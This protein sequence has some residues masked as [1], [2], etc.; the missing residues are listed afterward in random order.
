LNYTRNL[1]KFPSYV[2]GLFCTSLYSTFSGPVSLRSTVQ[3]S[4]RQICR[5]HVTSL[6]SAFLWKFRSYLPLKSRG[7]SRPFW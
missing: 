5:T 3:I 6:G 4:S 1:F 2:M 7:Y